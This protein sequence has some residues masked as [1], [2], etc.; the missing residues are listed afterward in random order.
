MVTPAS[1]ANGETTPVSNPGDAASPV[2]SPMDDPTP[3]ASAQSATSY[4]PTSPVEPEPTQQIAH[5]I[6]D[7]LSKL[8]EVESRSVD[9]YLAHRTRMTERATSSLEAS[10]TSA[11]SSNPFSPH[12]AHSGTSSDPAPMPTVARVSGGGE[13]EAGLS[14]R[15]ALHLR[16]REWS[17]RAS[18]ERWRSG[19][20]TR[21]RA[22]TPPLFPGSGQIGEMVSASVWRSI[23]SRLFG[24]WIP[25][26]ISD[27]PLD[28]EL[29]ESEKAVAG[30]APIDE[31]P[32][33]RWSALRWGLGAVVFVGV[34]LL[35]SKATIT[36]D[37]YIGTGVCC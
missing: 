27:K 7:L 37:I 29:P 15:E 11:D 28:L 22:C 9:A 1:R 16:R 13:W 32:R 10:I 34:G 23:W 18:R 21:R 5:D 8:P 30:T 33:K 17:E 6:I 26:V 25:P 2:L 31:R 35:L 3:M 19:R 20:P 36:A 24:P 14:R 4:F 12:S